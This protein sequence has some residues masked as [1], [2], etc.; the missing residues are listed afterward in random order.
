MGAGASALPVQLDKATA[1]KAAGDRWD[2]AAFDKVAKNGSI[3]RDEFLKAATAEK[4]KGFG[5]AVA[6]GKTGRG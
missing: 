1:Q 5:K 6:G 4:P 2:E 3:S